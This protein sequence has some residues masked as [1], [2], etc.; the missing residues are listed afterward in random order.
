MPDNSTPQPLY[1]VCRQ[2]SAGEPWF[3]LTSQTWENVED[4]NNSAA[5]RNDACTS[6]GLPTRYKVVPYAP[7]S[8]D[9]IGQT[10]APHGSLDLPAGQAGIVALLDA[11]PDGLTSGRVEAREYGGEVG[12]EIDLSFKGRNE[13]RT[14]S[15]MPQTYLRFFTTNEAIVQEITWRLDLQCSRHVPENPF[16]WSRREGDG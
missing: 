6:H 3:A 4:A 2:S 16:I 14:V 9:A 8:E 5:S 10:P 11:F 12:W 7:V 15:L 13:S 1:V